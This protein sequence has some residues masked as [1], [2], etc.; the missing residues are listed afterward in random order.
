MERRPA[1]REHGVIAVDGNVLADERLELA[2]AETA[3]RETDGSC[4]PR[5]ARQSTASPLASRT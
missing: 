2:R 3:E 5:V 4:A 1:G